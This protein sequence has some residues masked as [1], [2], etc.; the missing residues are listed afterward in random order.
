[1]N[2]QPWNHLL[3]ASPGMAPHWDGCFPLASAAVSLPSS[4]CPD[5]P[6]GPQ[7]RPTWRCRHA[8]PGQCCAC[9]SRPPEFQSP[10]SFASGS[11]KKNN[12]FAS[13]M[14]KQSIENKRSY[15][16]AILRAAP[17]NPAVRSNKESPVFIGAPSGSPVKPRLRGRN[18]G[19]GR[20]RQMQNEKLME[21]PMAWQKKMVYTMALTWV[22]EPETSCNGPLVLL[23]SKPYL[24]HS[25]KCHMVFHPN[26]NR[27]VNFE[28]VAKTFSHGSWPTECVGLAGYSR[29]QVL[30]PC[31]WK[32]A[33]LQLKFTETYRN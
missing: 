3:R 18:H 6:R 8:G 25:K 33:F 7:Q 27:I 9:C 12:F 23:K 20:L 10:D 4:S 17:C 32:S 30:Y 26:M 13:Q 11:C 29:T 28:K 5:S 14:C 22:S 2:F 31:I 1:M 21:P 15:P 16:R 19:D 24:L